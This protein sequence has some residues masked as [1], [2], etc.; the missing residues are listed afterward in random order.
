MKGSNCKSENVRARTRR[1]AK[2]RN[3]LQL[4]E[5]ISALLHEMAADLLIR[6][7]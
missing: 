6:L 3:A 1:P 4:D 2:D 5:Q 7:T